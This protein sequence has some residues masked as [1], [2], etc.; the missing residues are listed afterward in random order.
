[1]LLTQ[2]PIDI[3]DDEDAL[4]HDLADSDGFG[5]LINDDDDGF[6]SP[7]DGTYDV[8]RSCGHVLRIIRRKS[9]KSISSFGHDPRKTLPE[10]LILAKRAKSTFESGGAS[11]SGGC[12][13]DEESAEAQ[14]DEDEDGDGDS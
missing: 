6:D 10:P 3:T 12:G 1:M 11:G 2:K 9:G 14:E 8:R 7:Y 4:P 5:D 13:D